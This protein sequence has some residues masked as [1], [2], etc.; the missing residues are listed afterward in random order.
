[1]PRRAAIGDFFVANWPMPGVAIADRANPPL[2]IVSDWLSRDTVGYRFESGAGFTQ[3]FRVYDSARSRTSTPTVLP[4]GHI[5][6]GTQ[7]SGD[8][9]AGA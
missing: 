2:V 9:R 1:M 4:D 7:D 8:P 6:M 3:V 5:V